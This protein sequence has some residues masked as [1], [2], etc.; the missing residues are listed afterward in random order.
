[1][2]RALIVEKKVFLTKNYYKKMLFY[3]G[4]TNTMLAR[5]DG[6]YEKIL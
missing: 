2:H 1:M 6:S 5:T 3:E 4:L